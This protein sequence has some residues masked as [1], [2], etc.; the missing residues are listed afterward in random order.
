VIAACKRK[1]M[2]GVSSPESSTA[3]DVMNSLNPKDLRSMSQETADALRVLWCDE[4]FLKTWSK[5]QD[6][7]VLDSCHE[8]ATNL[9]SD[10]SWGTPNWTPTL[11]EMFLSRVRTTGIIVEDIAVSKVRI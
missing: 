8:L 1:G 4:G 9:L 3:L 11:R 5:R 7:Q 10:A 6:Y 2:C